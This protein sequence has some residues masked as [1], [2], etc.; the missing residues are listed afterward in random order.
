MLGFLYKIIIGSFYIC[1]HN[2][3]IIENL[4]IMVEDLERGRKIIL[5]CKKCGDVWAKKVKELK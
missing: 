4:S 2:W 3:E 5:Q 1:D